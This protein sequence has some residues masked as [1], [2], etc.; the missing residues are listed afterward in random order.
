MIDNK[1]LEDAAMSDEELDNVAGGTLRQMLDLYSAIIGVQTGSAGFGDFVAG[2]ACA[3]PGLN[4]N[5]KSVV[6][7]NL[8]LIGINAQIDIGWLGWDICSEDNVYTD[9]K[10]GKSLSHEEVLSRIKRDLPYW[11]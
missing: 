4:A 2:A 8:S 3:I 1:I 5:S 9:K 10:T 6:I 11:L 7:K